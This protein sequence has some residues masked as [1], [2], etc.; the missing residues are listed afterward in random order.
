MRWKLIF[1]AALLAALASAS[2]SFCALKT[3]AYFNF[4]APRNNL[5]A[6]LACPFILLIYTAFFVYRHTAR[7]RR[8]QAI[9]CPTFGALLTVLIYALLMKYQLL[10]RLFY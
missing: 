4:A 1:I 10:P 8:L 7:R 9:L 2:L 6:V 3:L 5:I